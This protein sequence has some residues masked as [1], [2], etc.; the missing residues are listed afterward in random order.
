[1]EKIK[2]IFIWVISIFF[3]LSSFAYIKEICF[4]AILLLIAGTLMLPPVNERIKSLIN[5]K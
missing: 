4:P 3:I 5:N 1:M 2:K